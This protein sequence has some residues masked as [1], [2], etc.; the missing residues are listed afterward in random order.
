MPKSYRLV[1]RPVAE[2][3]LEELYDY[4]AGRSGAATAGGYIGRVEA[5]CRRLTVFPPRGRARDDVLPG[6]RTL[7]FERRAVI[8]FQVLEADVR[9]VRVLYGGRDVEQALKGLAFEE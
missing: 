5:A 7:G 4:I 3:D 1:F 8:V 6:L 9:I 2:T